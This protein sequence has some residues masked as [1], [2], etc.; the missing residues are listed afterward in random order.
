M[1]KLV[2]FRADLRTVDNTAL[3][4]AARDGGDE[5]VGLYV[6]SP[7]EWRAHDAAAVRVDFV[8]RTLRALSKALEAKGIPLVVVRAEG[9]ADVPRLV[10]EEASRLGC[11]EAHWNH[12]HEVNE[13]RRDERARALLEEADIACVEHHDQTVIPPGEVMTKTGSW[14]TVFTP[15]KKAWLESLEE[16]GGVRVGGAPRKR[17]MARGVRPSEIPEAVDGFESE[18]DPGLWPAGEDEAMRRLSRFCAERIGRYKDERDLPAVDGTS[19]LSAH[20]AV[21]SISARQCVEAAMAANGGRASGGKEGP[22]TWISELV[23]REFYRSIL[24]GFPRI[25]MHRAFRTETDHL[26]WRYDEDDFRAWA[27]GRTGFPLVDA[28]MRQLRATGWM[29]NRVRMVTAMFLTKDLLID[30]RWGEKWFM[31]HL[32]DGDLAQN[33]GGWQ[34]SASTGTDAAPYFR[35]FNPASQSRRYDPRGEYIRRWVPEL[36]GLDDDAV[37]EPGTLAP[38]ERSTL[39]YPDPMVDHGRARDRAIAAFK[40]LN[41]D[42]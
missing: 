7:G 14:Y 8:L 11:G 2:W 10:A 38:L 32:I 21:G 27:E 33:N 41:A 15:F 37:H 19:G 22:A 40:A 30:W 20:L 13:A 16:R 34:W 25:C 9:A 39:D 24:A 5:L 4:A 31:R 18:V 6:V 36:E 3:L 28:G 29:H 17:E 1:K 42:R 23:W 26:G 12:Q 35:I